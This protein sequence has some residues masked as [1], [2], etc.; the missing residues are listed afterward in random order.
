MAALSSRLKSILDALPLRPGLR[1]LEVGCGPG[2]L[3]RAIAARVAPVGHVLGLDRSERAIAQAIAG[4]A[5]ELAAGM[6]SFRRGAIEEFALAAG[7]AP[8]DLIIAVRVGALDGRHPDAQAQAWPRI[9][10]ALAPG[11]CIFVDG[12]ELTHAAIPDAASR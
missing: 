7:E 2:A 8:F 12:V 6:V 3:A 1:V 11:G 9:R 5:A 10:A 4:S